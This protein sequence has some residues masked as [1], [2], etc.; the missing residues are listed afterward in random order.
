MAQKR[1]L[2]AAEAVFV[3]QNPATGLQN[4]GAMTQLHRIQSLSLDYTR[5]FT[6]VFQYGQQEFIDRK[7][8]ELPN[9]PL[10]LSYLDT[11]VYNE[12]G[13]GLTVNSPYHLFA[14]IMTGESNERNYYVRVVPDGSNAVNFT[15]PLLGGVIGIG[16]GTIASYQA[17]GAVGGFPTCSVTINALNLNFTAAG[18]SGVDSPAINVSNGVPITGTLVSLP[19]PISGRANQPTALEPGDITIDLVQPG[20]GLNS[21]CIQSY[22]LQADLNLE[23]IVCLGSKYPTSREVQ[24]PV[25]ASLSVELNQRDLGTG[26]LATLRCNNPKYDVTITIRKPVCDGLSQGAVQKQYTIRG[27]TLDSQNFATSLNQSQSATLSFTA[28]IGGFNATNVG[29]YISGAMF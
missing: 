29:L 16:N 21:I 12:S 10:S 4:S 17:Q 7:E 24:F 2:P 13:M 19:T 27:A 5:N 26:N 9:V 28:P 18:A 3:S 22:N 20:I 25:S 11:N 15:N 8:L 6:D 1:I 23:P 14:D